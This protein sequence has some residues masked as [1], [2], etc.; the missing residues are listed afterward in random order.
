VLSPLL[1]QSSSLGS[2]RNGLLDGALL[3]LKPG[4]ASGAPTL[5]MSVAVAILVTL[6]WTVILPSLGGWRMRTRDA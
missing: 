6:A 1:L 4:P 3:F 2:M 5:T